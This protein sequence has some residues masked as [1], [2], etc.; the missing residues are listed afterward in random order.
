MTD[1]IFR[2]AT[3]ADVP[4]L[5][6]IRSE[7]W[8]SEKFWKSRI[9][10]YIKCTHHPQKALKIRV[11]YV[12]IINETIAGFIGGHLTRRFECD[13]EVQWIN[14]IKDFRRSGIASEL[15]K[16][17]AKWFINNNS[18]KVCVDPGD[19]IA[20]RFYQKNRAKM[21]DQHWMFWEDIRT[22]L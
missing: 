6:K 17:L 18:F 14:V 8:Q 16:L 9:S 4:S 3:V 19:E 15:L 22:T 13:G 21:L 7:D 10:G 20:V 11:I 12:A 5:A 1:V 2:E